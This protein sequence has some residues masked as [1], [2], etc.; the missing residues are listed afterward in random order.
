MTAKYTLH[1]HVTCEEVGGRY[2]LIAYGPARGAIPYLREIN[3]TGS[4]FWKLL[5]EGLDEEAMLERSLTEYDAPREV[6]EEGLKAFLNDLKRH[7]YLI[8]EET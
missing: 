3:E 2:F 5:E 6:M 1:P 4:Y 8:K 7:N